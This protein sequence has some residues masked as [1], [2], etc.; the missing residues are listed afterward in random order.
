MIDQTTQEKLKKLFHW[1]FGVFS[2]SLGLTI[3]LGNILNKDWSPVSYIII[4]FIFGMGLAQILS[5]FRIKKIIAG[6][7]EY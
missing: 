1:G 7:S 4:G 5:Y 3:I 2:F 6:S